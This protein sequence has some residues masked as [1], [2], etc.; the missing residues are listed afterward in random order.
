M[1]YA[2]WTDDDIAKIKCLAGKVPA[3]DIAAELGRSP[4]YL[5]VQAS[6][7]KIPLR[8]DRSRRAATAKLSPVAANQTLTL[9]Q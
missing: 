9:G 2:K 5:A 7:L 1:P 8:C 6:K 4:G 3:K